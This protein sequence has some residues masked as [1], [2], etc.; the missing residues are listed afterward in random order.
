MQ[1]KMSD[2]LGNSIQKKSKK[3]KSVTCCVPGCGNSYLNT[4]DV[5]FY[6]FPSKPHEC[7]RREKWINFVNRC[8]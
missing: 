8:K 3:R 4:E 2:P 6:V 7:D 1:T 5:T